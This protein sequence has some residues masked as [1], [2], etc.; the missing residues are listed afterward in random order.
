VLIAQ[1]RARSAGHTRAVDPL[2]LLGQRALG[3]T[4]HATVSALGAVALAPFLACVI[5][6]YR[7]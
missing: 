4:C 3:H 7:P 5:S 2:E 1:H 6:E